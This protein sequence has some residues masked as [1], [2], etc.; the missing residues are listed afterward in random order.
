MYGEFKIKKYVS[1]YF[2]N[3]MVKSKNYQSQY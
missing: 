2:F 1:K 3:A